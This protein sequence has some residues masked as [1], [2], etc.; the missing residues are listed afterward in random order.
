MP[1]PQLPHFQRLL[2]SIHLLD[3]SL[4]V[5]LPSLAYPHVLLDVNARSKPLGLY[6]YL[7]MPYPMLLLSSSSYSLYTYRSKIRKLDKLR[8][9]Y[10]LI[11]LRKLILLQIY[12]LLQT[13]RINRFFCHCARLLASHHQKQIQ[14]VS[15]NEP[16]QSTYLARL[17]RS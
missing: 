9:Q 10:V 7:A 17:Y 15:S 5:T 8:F 6:H 2:S 14:T 12:L 3:V 4:P 16:L 1:C 13:H 11:L